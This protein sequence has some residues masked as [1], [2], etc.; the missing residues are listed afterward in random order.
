MEQ[1][2]LS[3][4]SWIEELRR[5]RGWVLTAGCISILLGLIAIVYAFAATVV[6]VIFLGALLIVGGVIEAI[7][8]LRHHHH[9]VHL[10]VYMLEALF[11]LAAGM[12]LLRS[13][14]RGAIVITL[15]LA[16]YFVIAGIFRIVSS[17]ALQFPNWG[18][19]VF[20]GIITLALGV[21]VW[22][23]WPVTGL[24]V[25]GLFIGINLLVTGWARVMLALALRGHRLEPAHAG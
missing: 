17:L 16:V 22:G 10:L 18:W 12:L 14:E 2:S 21:I 4:S 1:L 9:G 15:L 25:L 5:N 19:T 24:W 20:N 6:S 23:G 13:P 8:A 7:Y 11:A 3:Y